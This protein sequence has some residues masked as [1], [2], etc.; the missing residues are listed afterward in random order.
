MARYFYFT[1]PKASN[2][3]MPSLDKNETNSLRY[4]YA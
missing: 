1:H 3:I 2:E 4:N